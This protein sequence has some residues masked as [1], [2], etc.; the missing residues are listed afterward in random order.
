[1]ETQLKEINSGVPQGSVLG[2]V[3][4]LLYTANIPVALGSTTAT[5][6]VILVTV[7]VTHKNHIE[8]S[9][10]LEKSFLNPKMTKKMKNQN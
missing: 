3:L 2:S 8:V 4:Y 9:L 5:Y 7:L 1:M 6:V 10:R